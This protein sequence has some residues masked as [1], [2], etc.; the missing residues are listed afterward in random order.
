MTTKFIHRAGNKGL[1]KCG[2]IAGLISCSGANITCPL[3]VSYD[4]IVG[5]V[6]DMAQRFKEDHPKQYAAMRGKKS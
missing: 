4:A 2:A 6:E 5:Q 3:C 1:P